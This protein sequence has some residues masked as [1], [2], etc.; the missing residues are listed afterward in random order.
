[1]YNYAKAE[2][3]WKDE[4]IDKT[5]FVCFKLSTDYTENDSEDVNVFFYCNGEEELM[6]LMNVDNGEDFVVLSYQLCSHWA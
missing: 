4:P 3:W 1:M 2:I 6:E 5:E